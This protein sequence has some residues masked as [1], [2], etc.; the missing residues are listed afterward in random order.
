MPKLFDLDSDRRAEDAFRHGL[1]AYAASAPIPDL[2]EALAA[3][4]APPLRRGRRR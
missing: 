2:D 4:L 1:N 3:I